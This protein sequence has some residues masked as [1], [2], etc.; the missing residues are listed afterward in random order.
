[1]LRQEE[2][3]FKAISTLQLSLALLRELMMALSSR[4]KKPVVLAGRRGT[5]C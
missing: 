3:A 5:T 4:K 2:L 1:L